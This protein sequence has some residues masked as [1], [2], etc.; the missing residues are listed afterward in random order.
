MSLSALSF[1]LHDNRVGIAKGVCFLSLSD[2]TN[3]SP[4][5]TTSCCS[6]VGAWSD[7]VVFAAHRTSRDAHEVCVKRG[8]R[9]RS[10][11]CTPPLC[12][13]S[14]HSQTSRRSRRRTSPTSASR[15]GPRTRPTMCSWSMPRAGARARG[16]SSQPV[17]RT[18]GR[19]SGRPRARAGCTCAR[20]TGRSSAC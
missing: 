20:R 11:A 15:T 18:R 17:L 3:S 10:Q 12:T 16:T 19:R 6:D 5:D 14:R 9:Q 13:S 4:K 2:K 1:L 7:V 8:A